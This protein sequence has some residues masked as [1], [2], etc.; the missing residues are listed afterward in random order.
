[1]VAVALTLKL[2]LAP[3]LV[4]ASSL[5]GRRWGPGVSGLLVALPVV[6]GPILLITTIEH[7]RRFGAEAANA[8]LLGLITL[9]GFA[10]V[11]AGVSERWGWLA[12]MVTGW[13]ACL[14]ADVALARLSVAAPIG[15]L[16]VLAATVIAG[17]LIPSAAPQSG[18]PASSSPAQ[19]EWPWWDLPARAAATA[20]L[21]C[22]VTGAAAGLG[23]SLTGVL[24]PF[25]TATSVVVAFS[26]AQH[27]PAQ[28]RP[29]LRGLLRGLV[30]FATF[31]FLLA[32][33]LE[34]AGTLLAFTVAVGGALAVQARI[35][36]LPWVRV[37]LSQAASD[38][39]APPSEPAHQS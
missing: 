9:A 26:L 12:T 21:V 19:E 37:F 11:I 18:S 1:M 28:T 30:G 5:A 25:P 4:V 34:P 35:I 6:A 20:A 14:I 2:L 7:G 31:C 13:G 23:P 17:R 15:L 29:M 36:L 39:P 8:S 22:T 3:L 10:V 38:S 24:A 16:L 27:G 32:V 33:L